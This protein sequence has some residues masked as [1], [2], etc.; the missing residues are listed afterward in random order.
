MGAWV[1]TL[2]YSPEPYHVLSHPLW[3]RG[4]KLLRSGLYHRYEWS[5]PLWVRGLKLCI[6]FVQCIEKVVASFMGAWVET[7]RGSD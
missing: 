3:V 2:S 7:K 5:H 4:L 1:E 6:G